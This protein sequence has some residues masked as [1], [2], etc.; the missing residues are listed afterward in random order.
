MLLT[1]TRTFIISGDFDYRGEKGGEKGVLFE[2]G[3]SIIIN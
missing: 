1:G 3:D 2:H